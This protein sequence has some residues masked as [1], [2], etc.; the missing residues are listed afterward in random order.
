MNDELTSK[1]Q[2][3]ETLYGDVCQI[4]DGARSRI[5]T[6]LNTEVCMTNWC[7][8]KR[9]KEDV[10]FNQRA[11]YGK[12]VIKNLSARLTERYGRGWSEKHLRHCLRSA[13]TFSEEEIVSAT[14]RQLTWTHLKTLVYIKDPLERQFYAQMCGMEHWDTRTLDEKIA[15]MLVELQEHPRTGT[16]QVEHLKH[17]VFE[18]T[19][20]RRIN[21]HN[22]SSVLARVNYC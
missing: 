1:P 7:V 8:G 5:A 17:F 21:K 20:S 6:Y 18:E 3:V 9:I 12:Q 13:E 14:Q 15:N 19:W 10:L 2:S 4:I 11:E 22:F 16:G